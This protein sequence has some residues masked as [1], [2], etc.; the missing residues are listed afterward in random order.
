MARMHPPGGRVQRGGRLDGAGHLLRSRPGRTDLGARRAR[1]ARAGGRPRRAGGGPPAVV[2]PPGH[3]GGIRRRHGRLVRHPA[4]PGAG[5]AAGR[6]RAPLRRDSRG[7]PYLPQRPERRL[8]DRDGLHGAPR[9]PRSRPL[10]G[11]GPRPLPHLLGL[12]SHRPHH[13]ELGVRRRSASGHLHRD[14]QGEG[15]VVLG[16]ARVLPAVRAVL[17]GRGRARRGAPA[18]ELSGGG[19]LPLPFGRIARQRPPP[20]AQLCPG[21]QPAPGPAGVV[22]RADREL[23]DRDQA[24]RGAPPAPVVVEL[25]ALP[26]R[27][28]RRAGLRHRRDRPFDAVR[29]AEG[30]ELHQPARQGRRHRPAVLGPHPGRPPADV[31]LMIVMKSRGLRSLALLAGVCLVLAACA[32]PVGTNRADPK[33]VL[34]DLGRSATTTGE[35]TWQTRNVLFEQGMFMEF[36]ERPEDVL[37]ALHKAMVAAGGDPDLLFALAE[38]SFLHAE[39]AGKPSYELAAAVYAYAFLFPEGSG[40]SPGR[41]DPRLRIAADLYNW[42]LMTAFQSEDG[43]TVVPRGGA[44]DLSFGKIDVEF[45]PANLRAGDRELYQ[46]TPIAELEVY[47]LAMRYRWPGIGA[48]LAA[49]SRP[50]DASKPGR[51]IVAPR[52]QVPLTALLRI[53]EARRALVEGQPLEAKLELHLAWDGESVKI[54]GEEVP[55]ENEPSAALALTFTGAP[56]MELEMLGFLG[57]V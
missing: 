32:S 16:G 22:Q 17:R 26:E 48:P 45:D 50:I 12:A 1:P 38:L 19:R 57:R 24:H 46:F 18:D 29:G 34:R 33:V 4:V 41:F 52:L 7:S 30:Q 2:G 25:E 44:F 42:A 28:A 14:P 37:A 15:G 47:G 8:S 49:L 53:S 9:G 11:P 56:V 3:R 27:A 31:T 36:E 43:S 23:H 5:L 13:H 40:S 51:D 20:P 35:P 39:A 6:G 21:H 54:A 10:Q 55:L